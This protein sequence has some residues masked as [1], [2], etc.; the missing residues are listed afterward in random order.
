M[1]SLKISTTAKYNNNFLGYQPCQ[2]VKND[3]Y[4]RDHHCPYHQNLTLLLKLFTSQMF[5]H[6]SFISKKPHPRNILSLRLLQ[7]V[8]EYPPSTQINMFKHTLKH[9]W[10][11]PTLIQALA[12]HSL[13]A[14]L[15]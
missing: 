9:M 13:G 2:L 12:N 5:I 4:F 7:T 15:C 10:E 8:M 1:Y 14:I 6:P 3:Q 11:L